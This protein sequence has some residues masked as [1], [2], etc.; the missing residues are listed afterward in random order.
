LTHHEQSQTPTLLGG[1]HGHERIECDLLYGLVETGPIIRNQHVRLVDAYRNYSLIY[2]SGR[3][4]LSKPVLA[5]EY[6]V[7][8]DLI[9]LARVHSNSKVIHYTHVDTKLAFR[10]ALTV[11]LA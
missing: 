5:I 7:I 10:P 1:L 3:E 8:K 2:G 9:E 11:V 4:L 6:Q